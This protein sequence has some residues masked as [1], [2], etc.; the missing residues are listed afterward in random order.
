MAKTVIM[1]KKILCFDLD[2][3]ICFTKGKQYLKAKPNL[4][5]I[6]IINEL[7]INNVFKCQM[8]HRDTFFNRQTNNHI[9]QPRARPGIQHT[10]RP[11][12]NTPH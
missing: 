3:V 1:K 10:N 7:Y 11:T 2:N 5:A 12:H 6:N 8:K 9:N 4:K